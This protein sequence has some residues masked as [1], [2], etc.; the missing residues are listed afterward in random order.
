MKH[1]NTVPEG[2]R[3]ARP[4]SG[5]G[6]RPEGVH[7]QA[8]RHGALPPRQETPAQDQT[9]AGGVQRRETVGP[10]GFLLRG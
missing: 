2:C 4:V 5:A 10:G 6:S 8:Q 3:R 7:G 9:H 1:H